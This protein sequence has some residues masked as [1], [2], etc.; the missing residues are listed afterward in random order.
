LNGVTI[1]ALDAEVLLLDVHLRIGL[2]AEAASARLDGLAMLTRQIP[3]A[4]RQTACSAAL[5]GSNVR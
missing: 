4:G 1:S 2:P 3:D 5:V